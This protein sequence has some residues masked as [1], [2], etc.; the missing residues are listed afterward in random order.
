MADWRGVAVMQIQ[1]TPLPLARPSQPCK[2]VGV[3]DQK[4]RSLWGCENQLQGRWIKLLNRLV[5]P[6]SWSLEGG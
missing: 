2:E 4:D 3:G 6:N 5:S 1:A